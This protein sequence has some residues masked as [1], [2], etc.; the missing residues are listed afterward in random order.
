LLDEVDLALKDRRRIVVEADDEAAL[1]LQPRPLDAPHIRHEIATAVLAL[2]ALRQARLLRRFDP[3]EDLVEAR[4]HHP[5]HEGVIVGEVDRGLGVEGKTALPLA[6]PDQRGQQFLPQVPLVADKVVVDEEDPSPPAR[7]PEAVQLREDPFGGFHP[8]P[9]AEHRGDAAEIAV[10]GAAAR[11]LHAH[12]GVGAMIDQGPPR[13]RRLRQL[14]Q[15]TRGVE[16]PGASPREVFEEG[17]ESRL[18]L[19]EHEVIDLGKAIR[20]DREERSAGDD[21]LAGRPT[22]RDQLH[23]GVPLRD[24]RAHEHDLRPRQILFPERAHVDIHQ[25][26]LPILRE[27]PRDRQEAERR[28]RGALADELHGM[29]ETPE[30]VGKSWIQQ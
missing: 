14:G 23:R 17:R 22:A 10:E 5:R 8:R 13:K 24:H 30:R 11:I 9:M 7:L 21:R 20:L 19:V 15:T 6:P 3:D 26:R 28:Q 25:S 18:R 16:M 4:R 2:V 1:H 27:H 29:L 12:R